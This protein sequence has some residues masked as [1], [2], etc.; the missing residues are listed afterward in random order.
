MGSSLQVVVPS[1]KADSSCLSSRFFLSFLP[2]HKESEHSSYCF[3]SFPRIFNTLVHSPTQLPILSY[4]PPMIPPTGN[5]EYYL[6]A[7]LAETGIFKNGKW[8]V[9][10][11]AA[12]DHQRGC[13]LKRNQQ[14]VSRPLPLQAKQ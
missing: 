6:Q 5:Q 9:Q 12:V 2:I 10:Q 4:F 11:T 1:L 8:T 3:V 13:E 7:M 14:R